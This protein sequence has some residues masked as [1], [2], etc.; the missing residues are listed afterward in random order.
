M[1][2][3]FVRGDFA[4]DW[5]KRYLEDKKVWDHSR[6]FQVSACNPTRQIGH[7]AAAEKENELGD[8]RPHPVCGGCGE[9]RATVIRDELLGDVHSLN[10]MCVEIRKICTQISSQPWSKQP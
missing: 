7:A 8:G 1:K 9:G 2:A 5:V 4:F 3:T 10:I 6:I